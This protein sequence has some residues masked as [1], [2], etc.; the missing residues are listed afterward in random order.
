M[1]L[2]ITFVIKIYFISSTIT[3]IKIFKISGKYNFII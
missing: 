2:N 1:K 3:K